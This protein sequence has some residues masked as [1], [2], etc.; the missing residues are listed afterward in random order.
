MSTIITIAT[1]TVAAVDFQAETQNYVGEK[2]SMST[3]E[4]SVYV[5]AAII[6]GIFTILAACVTGM[7]LILSTLISTGFIVNGP[8]VP[9]GSIQAP[10]STPANEA[11]TPQQTLSKAPVLEIA[12]DP[13]A[14]LIVNGAAFTA[15]IDSRVRCVANDQT[16]YINSGVEYDVLIPSGWVIVWDSWKAYWPGGK[17]EDDGL[18]VIY[19]GWEGKVV[20]VNGEY[21][22]VP[23]EWASFAINDRFSAI[24][25]PDRQ[26]YVLGHTP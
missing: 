6:T 7:F 15:P 8:G 11:G 25:R 20:V 16:G 14:P 21:C 3:P 2:D 4:R 12:A 26:I 13:T 24:S 23:I 1:A 17:Y 19:G 22:A 9:A 10:V 5:R 18:L